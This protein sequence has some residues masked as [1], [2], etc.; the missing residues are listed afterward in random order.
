MGTKVMTQ[1]AK[2]QK[3]PICVFEQNCKKKGNG[4]S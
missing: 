4:M 1:N 2:T 3:T